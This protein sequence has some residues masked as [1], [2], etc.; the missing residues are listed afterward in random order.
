MNH[1]RFGVYKGKKIKFTRSE[2]FQ[3]AANS[4]L[5][6]ISYMALQHPLQL[7][8]VPFRLLQ[9]LALLLIRRHGNLA[10]EQIYVSLFLFYHQSVVLLPF[11][12]ELVLFLVL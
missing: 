11:K 7:L 5:S 8:Q 12:E 6:L 4:Y 10:P 3:T 9:L 1:Y 2:C